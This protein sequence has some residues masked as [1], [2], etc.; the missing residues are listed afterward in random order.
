MPMPTSE[1]MI[2]TP[3]C[4][5]SNVEKNMLFSVFQV[6]NVEFFRRFRIFVEYYPHFEDGDVREAVVVN[7]GLDVVR[8]NGVP[9]LSEVYQKS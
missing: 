3:A 4:F 6:L 9:G 2:D 1:K 7:G 5:T 8:V